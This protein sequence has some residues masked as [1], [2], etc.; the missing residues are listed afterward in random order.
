V[1]AVLG[2]NE[3]GVLSHLKDAEVRTLFGQWLSVIGERERDSMCTGLSSLPVALQWFGREDQEP[4]VISQLRLKPGCHW[5]AVREALNASESNSLALE[6]FES[7]IDTARA[8]IARERP[9]P[10]T[11]AAVA[12]SSMEVA[13]PKR[14]VYRQANRAMLLGSIGIHHGS[15]Y[16]ADY[17]LA[18]AEISSILCT[19]KDQNPCGQ[20]L[21]LL[22]ES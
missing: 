7:R 6:A 10:V 3:I 22:G 8:L 21:E 12:I 16:E 14:P 4:A 2:E 17:K 1:H 11:G 13:T 19:T 18:F 15:L 9:A 20:H 5:P